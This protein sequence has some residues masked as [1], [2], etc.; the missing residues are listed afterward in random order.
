MPLYEY[1]CADCDH[2]FTDLKSMADYRQPS[3][4]PVCGEASPRT[5]ASAPRLNCM[6]ADLRKAHQTNERSAHAPRMSHGH[7]CGAGCNHQHHKPKAAQQ[8]A[9]KPA[10]KQQSGRRPWMLGH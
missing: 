10:L 6:R 5:L 7:S 2:V 3:A 8:A 9:E 4:C 1:F